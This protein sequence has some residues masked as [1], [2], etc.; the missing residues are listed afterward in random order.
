MSFTP[1]TDYR[2]QVRQIIWQARIERLAINGI[3]L[4]TCAVVL[5]ATAWL[6]TVGLQSAAYDA[7]NPP[8]IGDQP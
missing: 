2:R 8:T 7:A 1:G 6:A 5:V 4:L 3:A